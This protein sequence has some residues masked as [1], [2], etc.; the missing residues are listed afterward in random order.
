[1]TRNI[2]RVAFGLFLV[3]FVASVAVLLGGQTAAEKWHWIE[4]LLFVLAAITTVVNLGC[5]LSAQN[6]TVVVV[7]IGLFATIAEMMDARSGVPFG[8][9]AFTDALGDK[10]L[11]SVPWPMPLLWLAAILNSRGLARILLRPHRKTTYYGFWLIGVTGLLT[12]VF[13][14][15]LEPFATA[16][17][18]YWLW[19]TPGRV[20]AW[21]TAPWANFLGWAATTILILGFTTPWFIHKHP[22]P[23][24]MDL[25]P[26]FLWVLLSLYF[27]TG[28]ATQR[29]WDAV[30]VTGLITGVV[31]ALAV[32]GVRT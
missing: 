31:I 16:V 15:S 3:C 4:Q 8:P 32:R 13:A 7:L 6:A 24:S 21:H 19:Q 25:H 17:K 26:L 9:R 2:H 27:A 23:P 1:M 10:M 5:R 29:I 22:L 14:V 18:H 11:R 30:V 20:L 28:C 12:A